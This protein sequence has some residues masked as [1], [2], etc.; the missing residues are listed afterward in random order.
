MYIIDQYAYR[1]AIRELDPV[2]KSSLALVAILFCLSLDQPM[3]GLITLGWMAGLTILWARVPASTFGRV[4]LAEAPFLLL[5]VTGVALSV[6]LTPIAAPAVQLGPLWIGSSAETLDLALRLF[7]RALGCAA[8]LNFLILTTP[9]LDLIELL[10]R[11]R[12]PETLI[13]VM[14]LTYRTIFVLLDSF[15]RMAV[16]QDVR[17]GYSSPWRAMRSAALLGSQLFLE[18]YRRSQRM[19]MAL[20]SRGLAGSLRALPLDY[21]RDRRVWL[22]G[23]ALVVSLLLAGMLR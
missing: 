21:R 14:S 6:S 15:R 17:L 23:A 13:D 20:E 22:L 5:S 11:L 19:Q 8:A 12:M 10:R 9:L 18:A 4:L 7:T 16:A 3:V 1:N 2:Q